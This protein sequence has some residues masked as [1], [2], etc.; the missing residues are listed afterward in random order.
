MERALRIEPVSGAL[1]FLR[2]VAER[3]I[4]EYQ[5]RHSGGFW[6]RHLRGAGSCRGGWFRLH[7]HSHWR[8]DGHSV[9]HVFEWR[10]HGGDGEHHSFGR[11]HHRGAVELRWREH[12]LGSDIHSFECA[13]ERLG[14]FGSGG[15]IRQ[16]ELHQFV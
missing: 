7:H 5:V 1:S 9:D 11:C 13:V 4:L 2:S 12:D 15:A 6:P 3:D 8:I 14:W 16:P 10:R